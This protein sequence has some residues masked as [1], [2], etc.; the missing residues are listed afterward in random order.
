[1]I[2][3]FPSRG[4]YKGSWD[5]SVNFFLK[6]KYDIYFTRYSQQVNYLKAAQIPGKHFWLPFSVDINR[7]R[8]WDYVEKK[9]DVITSSNDRLDIYP[10]RQRI[11]AI[12]KNKELKVMSGKVY[13]GEYIQAI[14]Q[15]KIALI[16]TNSFG[17]AN[18][19]FTEF[20]ACGTMIMSD[21]SE[22]AE[23]MGFIDGKNIVIYENDDDMIDKI[24]YYLEHDKIREEIALNGYE[25]TIKNH[26][27]EARVIQMNSILIEAL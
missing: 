17:S 12:I 5:R 21:Y 10:N 2:D 26:S 11:R 19:K 27:N 25:L 20:S 4:D 7:Y 16:S 3:F 18:M 9:Y 22:D 8:K 23:D 13:H 14:N 1:V 6:N 15:S 24:F